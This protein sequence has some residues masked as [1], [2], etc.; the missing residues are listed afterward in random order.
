MTDMS[1]DSQSFITATG[2]KNN[3]ENNH[4]NEKKE[5]STNSNNNKSTNQITSDEEDIRI[6]HEKWRPM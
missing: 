5:L 2:Y 3:H 4:E 1:Y 6:L